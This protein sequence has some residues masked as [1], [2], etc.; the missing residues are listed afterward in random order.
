MQQK[1]FKI[2]QEETLPTSRK[3]T[4]QVSYNEENDHDF[5]FEKD[6]ESSNKENKHGEDDEKITLRNNKRLI[7][8][9]ENEDEER[10]EFVDENDAEAV[11]ETEVE[12]SG[13]EQEDFFDSPKDKS[14]EAINASND[15][16]DSTHHS[17]NH[18]EEEIHDDIS[19]KRTLRKRVN[20]IPES[21]EDEFE[22]FPRAQDNRR[23]SKMY[24]ISNFFET[25]NY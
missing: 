7:H 3:R 2:K 1:L 16:A 12:K 25:I 4:R 19:P 20:I 18:N 5:T 6:H 8:S 23:R 21:S 9:E 10:D 13:T 22:A 17:E 24:D 11:Q 15:A 14:A